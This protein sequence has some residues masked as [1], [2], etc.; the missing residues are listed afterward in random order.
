MP[1]TE[2]SADIVCISHIWWD[3]VWQRPQHLISRLA[4]RHRVLWVDEPRIEIGPASEAFEIA[5]ELPNLQVARLVL[6]SDEATFRRR[7]DET[8]DAS[9]GH[10]FEISDNIQRASLMFESRYQPRLEEEVTRYVASWR[11]GPLVLWLY[12]PVVVRFIDLLQPDVVVYDVMDD[13]K[14]FR[15]PP[16]RLV[17]QE[18]ELVSRADLLFAGGPTLYEDRR[19]RHPDAHLFP[20]GVDEAHFARALRDDLPIPAPMRGL[21]RPIVGYFGVVDE[22]TD[23]ALLASAARARPDWSWVMIGP[24]LKVHERR[25]PK[26]HNLHF[27]GKREYEELPAY[28]Q[29]FDVAMM[30]FAIN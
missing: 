9:G 25:L 1:T 24:M 12:T 4:R 8:R 21:P 3:F 26:L 18:R 23:F 20:S 27:L 17:D 2:H 14:A 22:R 28:L 30:P 19:S 15:F 16:R 7:L 29:A 6:R 13:L 5:D 11:R 10:P